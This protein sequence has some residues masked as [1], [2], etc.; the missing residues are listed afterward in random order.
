MADKSDFEFVLFGA[1]GF[2]GRLVAEY[3][4]EHYG[5]EVKW[6]IAGRNLEKLRALKADLVELDSSAEAIECV[7]ADSNDRPS[8][9]AMVRRTRAVCTTVGPYA[10]YGSNLVAACV[11]AGTDY[12]D[13][14][15]E[16]QWVR[17]MID[18]H[19]EAAAK[20]GARIVHCCGFDSIPSDLGT[21]VLQSEAIETYGEP[22]EEVKFLLVGV[23]GGFSGGTI[24]SMANSLEEANDPTVRRLMGNPYSL[25]PEGA[26]FGPDGSDQSWAQYD[27]IAQCWTAPF[28]MEAVNSRVVR[29]S[30]ALLDF[31]YGRNFRYSESMRVGEGPLAAVKAGAMS[32]GLGAF[33]AAMFKK[34]TRKLLTRF[35]LPDP[36]EGPDRESIERG[37]FKVVLD[38]RGGPADGLK[39]EVNGARDPGYGATATMLAESAIALARSEGEGGVLT[40]A[41]ALG[42]TLVDRLNETNVTLE[43]R[44]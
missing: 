25:N 30:N 29:R 10:V 5:D 37:Y 20:S 39:V 27:E 31:K 16:V 3:L 35:V 22:C 6:A 12:C 19:H 1:T 32:A 21:Y 36:G 44:D 33:A 14:T 41:V 23:S 26:A 24:A 8:L 34:P 15:G 4:V 43:V 38:G 18:R 17:R 9:D 28:V 2:A 42:S 7:V 40:P 11:E 13:L